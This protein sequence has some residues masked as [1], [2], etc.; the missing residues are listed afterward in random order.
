MAIEL[1]LDDLATPEAIDI[2]GKKILLN[3]INGAAKIA[4]NGRADVVRLGKAQAEGITH[5]CQR[6]H[7]NDT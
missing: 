4:E 7:K 2:A 3:A 6:E 5:I 1:T